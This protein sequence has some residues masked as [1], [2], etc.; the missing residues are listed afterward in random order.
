MWLAVLV[1]DGDLMFLLPVL[2]ASSNLPCVVRWLCCTTHTSHRI[3]I[4][5]RST[6]DMHL[7]HAPWT[8]TLDMHLGH[9]GCHVPYLVPPWGMHAAPWTDNLG[10]QPFWIRGH[11]WG[12]RGLFGVSASAEGSDPEGLSVKAIG[13]SGPQTTRDIII[14]KGLLRWSSLLLGVQP[15]QTAVG[16]P[17]YPRWSLPPR[18]VLTGPAPSRRHLGLSTTGSPHDSP[19]SYVV[20]RKLAPKVHAHVGCAPSLPQGGQALSRWAIRIG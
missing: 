7:G 8:C 15:P 14:S 2:L 11:P 3:H 12:P 9:L 5:W 17:G 18:V 16:S 4:H 10:V 6:L 20:W 13:L 1:V 19:W